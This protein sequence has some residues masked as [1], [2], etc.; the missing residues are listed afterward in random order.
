MIALNLSDSEIRVALAALQAQSDRFAELR[1]ANRDRGA[2]PDLV[3]RINV[4]HARLVSAVW[5]EELSRE[6][7]EEERDAA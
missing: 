4:L 6:L 2:S 5:A 3:K 1:R 7:E